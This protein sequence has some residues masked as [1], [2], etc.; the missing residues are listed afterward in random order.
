MKI[1]IYGG[2]FN[3]PHNGHKDILKALLN[4]GVVNKVY[5]VPTGRNYVK[6]GLEK[7]EH[8]RNMLNLCFENESNIE[9]VDIEDRD[10]QVYTYMTLDYFRERNTKDDIY[11]IMGSD[12]LKTFKTW[13]EYKYMIDNYHFVVIIRDDDNIKDLKEIFNSDKFMFFE[14]VSKLSSSFVR[15]E[16]NN[17]NNIESYLDI[18]VANYIKQNNLYKE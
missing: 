12:N 9:I 14:N 11:F 6:P 7:F 5:I 2:S 16:L 3:P 8:R 4:R 13:K 18:K 10:T 1:G 17:N 15:E